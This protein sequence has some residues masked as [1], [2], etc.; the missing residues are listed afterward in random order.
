MPESSR[1]KMNIKKHNT[2]H[3]SPLNIYSM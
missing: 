3:T 1:T 2:I